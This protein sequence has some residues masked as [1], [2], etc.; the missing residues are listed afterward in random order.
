MDQKLYPNTQPSAPDLELI[1]N[2]KIKDSQSFNNSLQNINLMMKYY[3]EQNNKN[4]KKYKK[5]KNINKFLNTFDTLIII[6]FECI[7]Y[8]FIN[9]RNWIDC[10]SNY[11]TYWIG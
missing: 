11:C 5:L 1:I 9:F 4:K 6:S 8:N 10:Y 3:E 7:F 2:Q